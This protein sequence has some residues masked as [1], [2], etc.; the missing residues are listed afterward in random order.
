LIAACKGKI[1][2]SNNADMTNKIRC[3]INTA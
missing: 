3:C 2:P 1:A